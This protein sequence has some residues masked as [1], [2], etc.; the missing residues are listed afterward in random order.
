MLA[1]VHT[2]RDGALIWI[3]RAITIAADEGADLPLRG[4]LFR[5]VTAKV[6]PRAGAWRV[7]VT[8]EYPHAPPIA[9]MPL[10]V[11]TE[12]E[13]DGWKVRVVAIGG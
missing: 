13:L 2:A 1:W 10:A 6:Y 5:P 12:L 8:E 7:D 4:F 3:D 11:G 9:G